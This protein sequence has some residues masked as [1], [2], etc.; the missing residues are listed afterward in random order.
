[1]VP[2]N[3]LQKKGTGRKTNLKKKKKRTAISEGHCKSWNF[4]GFFFIKKKDNT[5]KNKAEGH[6]VV[7]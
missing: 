3:R 4:V 2:Q 7:Q 6:D 5:R 1:M